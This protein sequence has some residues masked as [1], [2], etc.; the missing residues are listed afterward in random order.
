[1]ATPPQYPEVQHPEAHSQP[2]SEGAQNILLAAEELFAEQGFSAVSI[3][4][5]ALQAGVCKANIFHHFENKEALY[6]AVL[7]NASHQMSALV[8]ELDSGEGNA[9]EQIGR[10]TQQH[11]KNLFEQSR[12]TQLILRQVQD[13]S[14]QD[15]PKIAHDVLG[16]NFSRFVSILEKFQQHGE[17]RE[18]I[19]PAMIATLLVGSN[20]FYF[21]I[22]SVIDRFPE[23]QFAEKPENFSSLLIDIVLNGILAKQ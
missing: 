18:D 14:G 21:Q 8:A 3:N 6:L 12:I 15:S 11:L 2:A 23:M 19:N 10:Y 17:L 16:E 20:V 7:R 4:A 9:S 5:I 13:E 1:M 22:Q